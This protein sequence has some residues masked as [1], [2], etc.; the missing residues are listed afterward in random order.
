MRV[1]YSFPHSIGS[2]G[3]GWTAWNQVNELIQAGHR[4]HLVTTSVARPL[5]G[6]VACSTTM[7]VRDRRIPHRV[8]GRN[9]AFRWHDLRAAQIVRS[10]DFDVVHAWP[11]SSVSTFAAAREVRT[12]SFR[13]L[14]NTHTAHAFEVV[15]REIDRLGLTDIAPTAHTYDQRVLLREQQEWDAAD[16]LLAPSDAVAQTFID[17]GFRQDQIARHQYGYSLGGA[18]QPEPPR[19]AGDRK[20][21]FLFVGRLEP[22]KGVHLAIEAWLASSA[23]RTS[24]FSIY[25]AQVGGFDRFLGMFNNEPGIEIQGFTS[26]PS[27]AYQAAD[28]LVL[29][30]L[31]EGSALVTYEA[32]GYGCAL[33]V[34]AA[35][36]AVMEHQR[37]G[38]IHEPG[39][40]ASLTEHFNE[41][42]ADRPFLYRLQQEAF[43]HADELTWA[44]ANE[45]LVA[46]Y[47]HGM[48]IRP[49]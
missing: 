15:R 20:L 4:V 24:T 49:S 37:H 25:G 43:A 3:I 27:L 14:P 33:L 34:S 30:S 8:I 38:L 2:P 11:S 9:R 47:R 29:P 45:R 46:A 44:A 26:N 5:P 39:D 48:S 23:S 18:S 21:R 42:N 10:G 28:V 6:L 40:V 16:F 1:L 19:P 22:R 31:E 7:S 41:V 13:E 12:P 36:G 32:Q 35:A 17:R